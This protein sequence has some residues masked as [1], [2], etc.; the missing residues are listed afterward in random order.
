MVT[1]K[2]YRE[3]KKIN[4]HHNYSYFIKKIYSIALLELSL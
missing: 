2:N 4:A 1:W 3:W